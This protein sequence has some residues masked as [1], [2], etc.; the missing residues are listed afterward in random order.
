MKL[1]SQVE[2]WRLGCVSHERHKIKRVRQT[3]TLGKLTKQ[4]KWLQWAPRRL[5]WGYQQQINVNQRSE[6]Q[7]WQTYSWTQTLTLRNDVRA[8]PSNGAKLGKC[9]KDQEAP[10]K[11]E[12]ALFCLRQIIPSRL[13]INFR[14][15][16][17]EAEH[18]WL[19]VVSRL[20]NNNKWSPK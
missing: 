1:K 20:S 11:T 15:Q 18:I 14:S 7:D 17:I 8:A 9:S 3:T 13:L 5:I 10:P 12:K 19:S 16:L 6:S 4:S 2:R